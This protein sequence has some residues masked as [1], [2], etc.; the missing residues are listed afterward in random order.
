MPLPLL[1]NSSSLTP[2]PMS[3]VSKPCGCEQNGLRRNSSSVIMS[4]ES[5]ERMLHVKQSDEVEQEAV[6]GAQQDKL[7]NTAALSVK[8]LV[9]DLGLDEEDAEYLV[10]LGVGCSSA[11]DALS[12]LGHALT[13][14]TE[15]AKSLE[16]EV[17]QLLLALEKAEA[18]LAHGEVDT[19]EEGDF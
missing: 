17:E 19:D 12:V 13:A 9:A 11:D 4:Y 18:M 1:R 10:G 14:A 5:P 7:G 2:R 15:R 16:E 8:C 6:A 3:S